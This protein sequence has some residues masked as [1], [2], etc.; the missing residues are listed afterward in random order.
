MSRPG[1]RHKNQRRYISGAQ[2]RKLSNT[3]IVQQHE[4]AE[5]SRKIADLLTCS[6]SLATTDA[7]TIEEL[8]DEI[9]ESEA[10]FGESNDIIV[11]AKI[12][13]TQTFEAEDIVHKDFNATSVYNQN[14]DSDTKSSVARST[15]DGFDNDIGLWPESS[16]SLLIDLW[17][18]KG[19][20]DLQNISGGDFSKSVRQIVINKNSGKTIQ[21]SCTAQM[22]QRIHPNGELVKRTWLCYSPTTGRVYCFPCKLLSCA[23]GQFTVEG[24][25]DWKHAGREI[26]AHEKSASHSNSVCSLVQ[27]AHATGRIDHELE[28]Q[29]NISSKYWTDILQR[30]VCVITLIAERGLAFRGENETIGSPKNG[31]YLGIVEL[32]AKYDTFLAEHIQM[33]AN[34]GS[35]HTN[36][37]SSTICDEIIEIMGRSVRK[38][39]VDRIRSSKY[40]SVT[41]D[42]TPDN[43]HIDQLTVVL[44]YLENDGPVE[45]FLTFLDNTGHKGIE[46][47]NALLTF[48]QSIDLDISNCRGQSYD[49]ASNMSGKY[50]GMQTIIRQ[51]SPHA[52]FVP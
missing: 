2:K 31:N 41:V 16:T 24:F 44:R 6:S 49:N 35:G 14:S 11:T 50:I 29:L 21:R 47:A 40:F 30:V 18:T 27:R 3:K 22:F 7:C 42:S 26:E 52:V 32:L 39:I 28:Q 1:D 48:L 38:I 15:N 10:A 37:L 34:K 9:P 45:R 46:M 36:Y 17:A 13:E 25:D 23:Q 19:S 5:K 8:P 4:A 43:S 20:T 33:H 51:K 12:E